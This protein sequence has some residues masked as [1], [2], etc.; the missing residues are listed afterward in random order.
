[1]HSTSRRQKIST[2]VA[3]ETHEYLTGLVESGRATTM[4]EALDQTVLR[5]RNADSME[6][7]E[8]DT[9]A[10]FQ[11]LNGPAGE[12]ESRMEAAFGQM[13]DKINFDE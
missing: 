13:A 2:T 5:A 10:Y 9:A 6:L 11:A 3:P 4:S 7:L 1:M 12:E 8:R